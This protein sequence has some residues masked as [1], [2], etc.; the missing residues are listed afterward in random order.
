MLPY[1]I[2]R[3][4]TYLGVPSYTRAHTHPYK[5]RHIHFIPINTSEI[6]SWT[7]NLEIDEVIVDVSLLTCTSFTSEEVGRACPHALFVMAPTACY[8]A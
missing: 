8:S 1:P 7:G 3:V 6:L 4:C 2:T 5:H